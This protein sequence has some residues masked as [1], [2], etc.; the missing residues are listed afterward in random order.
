MGYEL[1]C[2][3]P[4]AYDLAYATRLGLGVF[5]LFKAGQTGCMVTVDRTGDISP[6]FLKDV[7]DESGKVIPRLVNVES[8]KVQ[9]IYKNNLHYITKADYRGAKKYVQNPEEFDFNKILDWE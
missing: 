2:C 5:K 1:R 8:E 6:L 9:L 4:I 7:E 3:R